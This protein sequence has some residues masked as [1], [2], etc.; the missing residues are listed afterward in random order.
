MFLQSIHHG[1]ILGYTESQ[2]CY[3]FIMVAHIKPHLLLIHTS[4]KIQ[5]RQ[6]HKTISLF[7]LVSFLPVLST[8]IESQDLIKYCLY[9]DALKDFWVFPNSLPAAMFSH[10]R[11][12]SVTRLQ[13]S[14]L[15]HSFSPP[16][17]YLVT[18]SLGLWM[19]CGLSA[20]RLL[21]SYERV[22]LASTIIS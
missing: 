21:Y 17:T 4:L 8:L 2:L 6:S 14:L 3:Y 11:L 12:N 16:R 10:S 22:V 5:P 15:P 13:S 1:D 9:C 19:L 7:F 20:S 18:R